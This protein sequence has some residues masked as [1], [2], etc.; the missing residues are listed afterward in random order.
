[1]K[2]VD[3][4]SNHTGLLQGLNKMMLMEL[5]LYYPSYISLNKYLY[6]HI[7]KHWAYG[8]K[9]CRAIFPVSMIIQDYK[10]INRHH[11]YLATPNCLRIISGCVIW[12]TVTREK[13]SGK[14]NSSWPAFL[15]EAFG[16]CGQCWLCYCPKGWGR[17]YPK[18]PAK[19]SALRSQRI[20]ASI[21]P[22]APSEQT[23]SIISKQPDS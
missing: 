22:W 15:S 17:H 20:R 13:S 6:Q 9:W 5:F 14:G 3:K 8:N 1:M 19:Y 10:P 16:T 23:S 18:C 2:N 12:I 4:R 7:H 11:H 21:R